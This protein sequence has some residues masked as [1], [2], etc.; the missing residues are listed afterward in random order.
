MKFNAN[1][2][3]AFSD[4]D[5]TSLQK[6]QFHLTDPCGSFAKLEHELTRL[7][8]T[9]ES[10]GG[11]IYMDLPFHTMLNLFNGL[12]TALRNFQLSLMLWPCSSQFFICISLPKNP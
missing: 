3:E 4:A 10:E 7:T 2:H 11:L 12:M 1:H 6:L 9:F 8:N 5:C